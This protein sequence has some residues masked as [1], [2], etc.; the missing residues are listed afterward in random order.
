MCSYTYEEYFPLV[1]IRLLFT[2]NYYKPLWLRPKK[3]C[4]P[5]NDTSVKTIKEQSTYKE[6]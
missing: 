2:N 1:K 6:H 4:V 5:T 3:Y